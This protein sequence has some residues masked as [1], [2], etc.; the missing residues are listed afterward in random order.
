MSEKVVFVFGDKFP[1]YYDTTISI[2]KL[3]EKLRV[4]KRLVLFTLTLFF[5]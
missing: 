5:N 2:F 3:H 1:M 4:R